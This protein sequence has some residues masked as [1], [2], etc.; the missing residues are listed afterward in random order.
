MVALLPEC[1]SILDAARCVNC[2][3]GLQLMTTLSLRLVTLVAAAALATPVGCSSSTSADLALGAPINTDGGG[4]EVDGGFTYD[5]RASDAGPGVSLCGAATNCQ[6]DL[7]AQDL[8]MMCMSPVV[9]AG[10]PSD[11][12][13]YTPPARACHVEPSST[14]AVCELAGQGKD[15]DAC[16]SGSDCS[17]GFE[18]VSSPGRCRHYCCDPTLCGVLAKLDTSTTGLFCDVQSEAAHSGVK[19]PVCLP[20]QDCQLLGTTCGPTETCAIVDSSAGIKSCVEIGPVNVGESCEANHCAANLSC[21]G[22][23]GKR[24]CQQL[25][26]PM[27]A[28]VCPSGQTCQQPW[29]VLKQDNAGIC[30]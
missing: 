16:T 25:C 26:D 19:V 20:V 29:T 7:G 15:G 4:Q 23:P 6:P 30:K 18:C 22:S 3:V 1:A 8:A 2:R 5:G 28:G 13:S 21:L 10:A 14:D 24:V 17:S 12:G 27:K 11:G 9:D